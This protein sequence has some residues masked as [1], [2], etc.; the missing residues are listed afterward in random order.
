MTTP[1]LR[2]GLLLGCF[3]GGVAACSLVVS[4][5]GL[6][7]GT[8]ADA[9]LVQDTSIDAPSDAPTGDASPDSPV[10]G[11]SADAGLVGARLIGPLSGSITST[12]TPLLR[13]EPTVASAA[14]KLTVCKTRACGA[15]DVVLSRQFASSVKEYLLLDDANQPFPAGTYYWNLRAKS[16]ALEGPPSATWTFTSRPLHIPAAASPTHKVTLGTTWDLNGDGNTEIFAGTFFGDAK[17]QP[18]GGPMLDPGGGMFAAMG[19]SVGAGAAPLSWFTGDPTENFDVS[20]DQYAVI[21]DID[22]D[23]YLDFARSRHCE[24]GSG[25]PTQCGPTLS[26]FRGG[27]SFS[28]QALSSPSA[29]LPNPGVSDN[30]F[31]RTITAAGDMNGDGYA[32]FAVSAVTEG[33]GGV[34]ARGGAV[35]LYLGGPDATKLAPPV[36][37]AGANGTSSLGTSLAAVGD[38]DAD[39]LDDLVALYRRSSGPL[40]P[41]FEARLIVGNAA[42]GADLGPKL[43]A[44]SFAPSSDFAEPNALVSPQPGDFDGDGFPDIALGVPTNNDQHIIVLKGKRALPLIDAIRVNGAHACGTSPSGAFGTRFTFAGTSAETGKDYLVVGRSAYACIGTGPDA[45]VAFHAGQNTTAVSLSALVSAPAA[46]QY[47]LRVGGRIQRAGEPL[48]CITIASICDLWL[49][50]PQG[51]TYT[52]QQLP[53]PG[54]VPDQARSNITRAQ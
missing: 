12:R 33:V 29:T 2:A 48:S 28:P 26:V 16:E 18:D 47:G 5:S 46:G 34:T 51:A 45:L 38:V 43:D 44:Y 1:R 41:V 39:G 4:T 19:T 23:G 37:I 7:G 32:D 30:L 14:L 49:Y 25:L 13:W 9:G 3:A 20:D 53:L 17:T 8:S 54:C 15:A 42:T 11:A 40:V 6:S 36:L 27:P 10:D 35:Y 50:C 31:G 22:G 21:G 24:L 52:R